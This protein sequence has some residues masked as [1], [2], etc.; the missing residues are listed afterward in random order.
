MKK[1]T[2]ENWNQEI[3]SQDIWEM[4]YQDDEFEEDNDTS[5]EEDEVD[6]EDL[7]STA[8]NKNSS[9]SSLNRISDDLE[10]PKKGF[11][12]FIDQEIRVLEKLKEKAE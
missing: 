2:T 4:S 9:S 12:Y 6:D 10:N 3:K 1:F 7:P 8:Q 5:E 11:K